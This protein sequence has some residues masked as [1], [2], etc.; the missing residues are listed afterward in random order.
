MKRVSL[1]VLA[2]YV[3]GEV[4]P[5]ET[6]EIEAALAESARARRDFAELRAIRDTLARPLP[7]LE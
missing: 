5:S 7:E 1:E 3:E 2:A 4:T 6:V